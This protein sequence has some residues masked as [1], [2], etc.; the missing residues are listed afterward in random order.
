MN[1]RKQRMDTNVFL[2]GLSM[3]IEE[4]EGMGEIREAGERE[5][6]FSYLVR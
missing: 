5:S 3:M 2:K 6:P 1:S 4:G